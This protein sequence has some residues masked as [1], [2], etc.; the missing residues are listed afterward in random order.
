MSEFIQVTATVGVTQWPTRD[1]SSP[2]A[3]RT[4]TKPT[5]NAGLA[6]ASLVTIKRVQLASGPGGNNG[7]CVLTFRDHE[8]ANTLRTLNCPTVSG[9][10]MSFNQGLVAF[11][12]PGGFA[13]TTDSAGTVNIFIEYEPQFKWPVTP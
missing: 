2:A 6:G 12:I 10:N 4:G 1:N 3:S 13:V 9:T 8:D 7:V 5:G 11:D